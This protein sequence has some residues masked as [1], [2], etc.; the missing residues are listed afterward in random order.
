MSLVLKLL[1]NKLSGLILH[2]VMYMSQCYSH[3]SSHPLF[4]P[5]VVHKSVLCVCLSVAV[6]QIGSLVPA[7][8]SSL[9]T[10]IWCSVTTQRG[11]MGWEIGG[12]SGGRGHVY[13]YG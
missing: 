10:Q 11:G 8:G 12:G 3:D 13:S 4:R 2:T 7:S 5:P 1:V 9:G 6:L